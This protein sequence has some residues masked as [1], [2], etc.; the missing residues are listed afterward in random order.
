MHVAGHV[1]QVRYK[2]LRYFC[3]RQACGAGSFHIAAH[4][5]MAPPSF[6]PP[7]TLWRLYFPYYIIY[8]LIFVLRICTSMQVSRT[9]T[10]R[11]RFN[12]SIHRME[13]R[14][15]NDST[16]PLQAEGY[17]VVTYETLNCLSLVFSSIVLHTRL[18]NLHPLSY[19][20]YFRNF[21]IHLA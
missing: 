11:L 15:I 7:L 17:V 14:L 16:S 3:F 9:T 4:A 20:Y 18:T 2:N 10:S 1:L 8:S 13:N 19:E 12:I 21:P 6:S 5:R